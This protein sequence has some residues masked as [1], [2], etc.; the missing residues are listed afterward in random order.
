MSHIQF[1]WIEG[2]NIGKVI[3]LPNW[4]ADSIQFLQKFLLSS[5]RNWKADTNMLYVNWVHL[6]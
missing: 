5:F 1:S 6:K 4:P 3:T 2:P